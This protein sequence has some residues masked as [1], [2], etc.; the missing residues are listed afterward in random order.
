MMGTTWNCAKQFINE[1]QAKLA[2]NDH[3]EA[4]QYHEIIMDLVQNLDPARL[5]Q[6]ET[7]SASQEFNILV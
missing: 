3:C 6:V 4:S 2:L 7:V 5:A 1:P